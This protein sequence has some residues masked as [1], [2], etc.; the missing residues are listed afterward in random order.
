MHKGLSIALRHATN[1]MEIFKT[2]LYFYRRKYDSFS[3]YTA[4]TTSHK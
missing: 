3:S 1:Q 4:E 2:D